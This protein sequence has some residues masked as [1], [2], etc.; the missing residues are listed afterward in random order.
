MTNIN[1]FVPI[2]M[3]YHLNSPCLAFNKLDAYFEKS[4]ESRYLI[5][6]ST[7]KNK[8]MLEHYTKL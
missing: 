7:E 5:F 8:I 4:R 6:A 1:D 3:K 2:L